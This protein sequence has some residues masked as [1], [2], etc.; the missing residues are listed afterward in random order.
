MIKHLFGRTQ[1]RQAFAHTL[2]TL[3]PELSTDAVEEAADSEYDAMA[4]LP[5]ER[6]A[7]SYARDCVPLLQAG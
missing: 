7:L 2:M 3:R 1:W 6:A 5:P 4:A